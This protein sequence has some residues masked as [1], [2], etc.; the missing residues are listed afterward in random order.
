MTPAPSTGPASPAARPPVPTATATR[1]LP[2]LGLRRP[3]R[4]RW[5]MAGVAAARRLAP[6]PC[7][8][9]SL[10][11]AT[12]QL[13]TSQLLLISFLQSP[14]KQWSHVSASQLPRHSRVCVFVCVCLGGGGMRKPAC[15]R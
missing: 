8:K 12:F 4:T 6:E 3:G 2:P 9:L 7:G 14:P 10:A 1:S 5:L 15:R 13:F 11:P